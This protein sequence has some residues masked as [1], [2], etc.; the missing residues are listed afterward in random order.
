M[1]M[2]DYHSCTNEQLLEHLTQ[3]CYEFYR[4]NFMQERRIR[5]QINLITEEIL[6]RMDQSKAEIP[7]FNASSGALNK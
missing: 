4:C 5:Y 1:A 2:V 3:R 6:R 7:C